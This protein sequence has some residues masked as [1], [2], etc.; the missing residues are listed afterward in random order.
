MPLPLPGTRD[1][2][3]STSRAEEDAMRRISN[4][5]VLPLLVAFL[6]ISAGRAAAVDYLIEV[7][8]GGQGTVAPPGPVIVPAGGSQTFTFTPWGCYVVG[9]ATVD[10]APV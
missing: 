8:V 2:S 6:A 1:P 10:D 7:Q 5:L 4:L 9:E 3:L